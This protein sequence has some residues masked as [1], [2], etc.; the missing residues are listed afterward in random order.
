MTR[1]LDILSLNFRWK[2]VW[3][4][5]ELQFTELA[6]K[7]RINRKC[8]TRAMLTVN[9]LVFFTFLSANTP[10]TLPEEFNYNEN[11]L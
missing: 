8:L 10:N 4:F 6:E 2:R 5:F 11:V 1:L 3:V 9:L 7:V